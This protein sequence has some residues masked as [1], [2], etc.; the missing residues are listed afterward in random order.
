LRGGLR[1][2]SLKI[3]KTFKQESIPAIFEKYFI[4]FEVLLK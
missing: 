2:A 4:K 3:E 1:A